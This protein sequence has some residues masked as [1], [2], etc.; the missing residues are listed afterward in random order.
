MD[1]CWFAKRLQMVS[2]RF[3]AGLRSLQS[4][5]RAK[6]WPVGL[7]GSLTSNAIFVFVQIMST[8]LSIGDRSPSLFCPSSITRIYHDAFQPPTGATQSSY[9][10]DR[11]VKLSLD[12]VKPR[13]ETVCRSRHRAASFENF[14]SY[15]FSHLPMEGSLS[16]SGRDAGY[17]R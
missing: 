15:R 1:C 9:L 17:L 3:S 2:R 13:R 12:G 4:S 14:V 8:R 16:I 5:G 11:T 7:R 6:S 10:L